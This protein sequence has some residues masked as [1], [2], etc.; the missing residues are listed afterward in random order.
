MKLRK[1]I[2]KELLK[3]ECSNKIQGL[4][5]GQFDRGQKTIQTWILE[6][7]SSL[8]LPEATAIISEGLKVKDTDLFE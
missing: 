2:Q 7:E 1:S 5:M 6:S 8:R 3:G 4:L